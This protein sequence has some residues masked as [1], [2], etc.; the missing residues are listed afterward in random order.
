MPIH[1]LQCIHSLPSIHVEWNAWLIYS[2]LNKWST[3]LEVGASASQFRHACPVVAPLGKLDASMV[4]K[5]DGDHDGKLVMADDLSKIDDL[6]GDFV[7]DDLEDL[8]G[9]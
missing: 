9:L 6:I 5:A 8:N 3:M 2:V 7:L 4:D 1:Q